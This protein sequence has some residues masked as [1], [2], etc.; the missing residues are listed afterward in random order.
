MMI[1]I[2]LDNNTNNNTTSRDTDSGR[3]GRSGGVGMF[4][5]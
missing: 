4:R 5:L 2:R 1:M 3:R